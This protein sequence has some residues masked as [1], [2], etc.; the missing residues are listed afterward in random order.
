MIKRIRNNRIIF[1]YI[2]FLMSCTLSVSTLQV[3]A[4]TKKEVSRS[5]TKEEQIPRERW[6][7]PE[8]HL[9]YSKFNL[10]KTES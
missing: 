10:Q 5:I 8:Q 4:A 2:L 6:I 9:L 1:L 3:S 7:F